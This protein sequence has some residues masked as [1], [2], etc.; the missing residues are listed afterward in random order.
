MLIT[1][2][3]SHT[4]DHINALLFSRTWTIFYFVTYELES[5]MHD[6]VQS[7]WATISGIAFTL[8]TVR[9]GL[10]W[11]T[12]TESNGTAAHVA[13]HRRFPAPPS[14]STGLESG[15]FPMHRA[16]NNLNQEKS[17]IKVSVITNSTCTSD[18]GASY[19]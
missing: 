3:P 12:P 2:L 18:S 17:G 14:V 19:A 15:S 16:A 13:R 8:I 10:G 9:I 11:S 5:N 6:F 4:R 1:F 7:T